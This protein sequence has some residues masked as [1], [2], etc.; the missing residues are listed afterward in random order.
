M[1]STAV[2]VAA[3]MSQI[4]SADKAVDA[5]NESYIDSINGG[6]GADIEYTRLQKT[7][8]EADAAY[9][10]LSVAI[11]HAPARMKKAIALGLEGR[12]GPEREL[13]QARR[14]ADSVL[15]RLCDGDDLE[16]LWCEIPRGGDESDCQGC[17]CECQN[18]REI[19]RI[20]PE[21]M[22]TDWPGR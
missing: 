18:C 10:A 7:V 22:H 12:A 21:M 2:R 19:V 6:G 4:G 3:A 9:A 14:L 15:C 16:L 5:A 20:P 17:I 8:R 13:A 1:T 11:A